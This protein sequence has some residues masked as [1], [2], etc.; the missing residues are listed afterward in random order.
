MKK[1]LLLPLTATLALSGCAGSLQ[2]LT[3]YTA[4]MLCSKVLITGQSAETVYDEDL[5]LITDGAAGLTTLNVDKDTLSVHSKAFTTSSTAIYRDGV[6]CTLVGV[7]GEQA[8]RDQRIPQ[9]SVEPLSDTTPWPYGNA[10]A[11]SLDGFDYASLRPRAEYHFSEHGDYQVK[12]SSLAIAY[13]GQLV[14]EKYAEGFSP[15][16]PIFGYSLGKTVA[17]L[18]GGVL[19]KKE[20]LDI[21]APAGLPEWQEDER[22]N[23]TPHHLLTMT[24]GLQWDE[25]FDDTSSDLGAVFS[26]EDLGSFAANRPLVASPGEQYNYSSGST[27]ILSKVFKNLQG[28]ELEG[29]YQGLHE[30]LLHKLN[31][32]NTIM[33]ADAS[34]SLGFG[35]QDLISTY[36]LAR[37]GQFIL[38]N[39][40]WQGEQLLP[41]NWI[42]YMS[43][44]VGLT[45]N[46]GF[47]YGSGLWLNTAQDGKAFFPSLPVDTL[48]GYGLRG[49][50]VIIVPSLKLVIVRTG[51]TMDMESLQFISEMDQLAADIVNALPQG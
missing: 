22:A 7:E 20:L 14:Y 39:G 40:Q 8:L 38:Q 21:H 23:I 37:L 36:D 45:T 27:M 25:V 30:S 46:L 16:T 17:A 44:P 41:E 5:V 9:L 3:S 6:G 33:Q 26:Q 43:A 4:S 24:S 19:V 29:T 18:Y 15:T 2:G 50:F 13:Q 49:Q 28:G 48:V 11:I 31:M 12:S 51:N 42:D 32:Q 1:T 10:E 35:A 34:G 47:D